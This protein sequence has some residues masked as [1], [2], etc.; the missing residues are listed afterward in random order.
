MLVIAMA[1]LVPAGETHAASSAGFPSGFEGYHDYAETTA[2]LAAAAEEHPGI[3]RRFSIGRS[4][5]GR[6]I[7]AVKISDNV[8]TDE[9]EPEVLM[10]SL[11]HAR[12]HLTVEMALRVIDLL[13]DNYRANPA[14]IQSQLERRVTNIVR[15]REIW[16]LPMVN[17]DGGEYD[18][19]GQDG[20]FMNWRR[21]TQ[22]I[23]ETAAPGIDLN[24]NW[25]FKW[26][27]C[28]GSSGKPGTSTFR[29]E[30]AW[31]APEVAALRDFVLGRVVRG[32][33]QIRAAIS[34]HAFNEEI[35]W[36]YGYTTADL[37]RTM[38]PDDLVAFQAIGH[39]MAALNGYVA[40]QLSDLY[41]LDGGASDWLY[42]DQRIFAFLVEMYPTDGSDAGG[43]YPLDTVITRETERNDEMVLYFLEN[44]DCP[45]RAAGL[46]VTHCGSLNDDF[47]TTRGWRLNS[48]GSDTATIGT[49]ERATAQESRSSTGI[50]QRAYGYSGATSLVT[51]ALR[52]AS[53]SANDVDGGVTS[54]ESPSIGLG[55]PGSIGWTLAFRYTFA[56]NSAAT[57]A[58]YLRI[59]VNGTPV[60]TQVGN[61]ASRNAVWAPVTVSLDTFA[62]Q[63]VRI[64]VSAADL[65]SDSLVEAAI[66]DVRVYR[67]P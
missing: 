11:H 62:G 60:F 6:E 10:D 59:S 66:D 15:S 49:W 56:H 33:Q 1:V 30:Y 32:R 38:S 57:A 28:G 50:K 54:A 39:G 40:Q 63:S 44:A 2:A 41:V 24:R 47:E 27:C 65:G 26:G 52:G 35:M 55:A 42:G 4:H 36:P 21:N 16:I 53:V 7:W 51:G 12:E 46:G 45:Y 58:D 64:L 8:A 17:P 14:N 37:P 29:G 13:T 23:D 19:S 67:V 34:W 48:G 22:P 25:G 31:Q 5:E 18:L 9:S 3:L 20:Q 61:R 43:F